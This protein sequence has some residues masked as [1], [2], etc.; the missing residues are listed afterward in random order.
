[1]NTTQGIVILRRVAPLWLTS[2]YLFSCAFLRLAYMVFV[3]GGCAYLVFWQG[4]S[5]WFFALSL[6]FLRFRSAF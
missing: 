1:M 2:L 6:F 4:V 5:A 3:I